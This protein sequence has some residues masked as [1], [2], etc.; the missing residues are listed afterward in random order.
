MLL[1]VIGEANDCAFFVT[2]HLSPAKLA[3]SHLA[4]SSR[5]NPHT[6]TLHRTWPHVALFVGHR[7]SF[8]M[9]Q[10]I[11]AC[12]HAPQARTT[13]SV[14]QL[15]SQFHFFILHFFILHFF[16]FSPSSFFPSSSRLCTQHHSLCSDSYCVT[17]DHPW[18]GA[19]NQIPGTNWRYK[20]IDENEACRKASETS[21]VGPS[22]CVAL[23]PPL[24]SLVYM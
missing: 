10:M 18:P 11:G 2:R 14:A 7:N 8:F 16:T 4:T 22:T 6:F 15:R 1:S 17:R 20:N 21:T 3:I 5:H 13:V 12:E 24:T 19:P 23:S 9:G